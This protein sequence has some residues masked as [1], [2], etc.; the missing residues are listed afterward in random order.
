[1]S[2]SLESK[3]LAL[4]LET[5]RLGNEDW[6]S[7]I[8]SIV[9]EV[10]RNPQ[11][12]QREE[13]K[14]RLVEFLRA[15]CDPKTTRVFLKALSD[16]L[17]VDLSNLDQKIQ[18]RPTISVSKMLLTPRMLRILEKGIPE[19]VVS[20][21]VLQEITAFFNTGEV[22][23][24]DGNVLEIR[25][26]S[27]E[28][29]DEKLLGATLSRIL[30]LLPSYCENRLNN[31][32]EIWV[33][34]FRNRDDDL[35]RE[36]FFR[37]NHSGANQFKPSIK[38]LDAD[39]KQALEAMQKME[40]FDCATYTQAFHG[41]NHFKTGVPGVNRQFLDILERVFSQ[42]YRITSLDCEF[43]VEDRNL[44]HRLATLLSTWGPSS[45]LDRFILRTDHASIVQEL[46]PVI[47]NKT[48]IPF[49]CI[50][51]N[52]D[53]G[54]SLKTL[55]LLENNQK[56]TTLVILAGQPLNTE[57]MQALARALHRN[58]SLT[59]LKISGFR[60]DCEASRVLAQALHTHKL[61]DA[62]FTA[63]L[64]SRDIPIWADM[65]GLNTHLTC[66]DLDINLLTPRIEM[67][68]A[69]LARNRTIKKLKLSIRNPIEPLDIRPLAEM[70]RTQHSLRYF[71]FND[72][73]MG[74]AEGGIF[75]R[76]LRSNS[77]LQTLHL[78]NTGIG[79]QT[80]QALAEVLPGQSSLRELN[81]GSNALNDEHLK[82]LAKGLQ[83]N[84]SILKLALDKNQFTPQGIVD[85]LS[86]LQMN[87]ALMALNLSSSSNESD[88]DGLYR[89]LHRLGFYGEERLDLRRGVL[90][91]ETSSEESFD[92]F[93]GD[94]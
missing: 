22:C 2:L 74:D 1:M 25:R 19:E 29:Q 80:I 89:E 18:L 71:D 44:G 30:E 68:W 20:D 56:L 53:I 43:R 54:A 85:F 40:G 15:E 7:P 73:E 82:I 14:A 57:G 59:K 78:S 90:Q 31:L 5:Y 49:L 94:E 36:L 72:Y 50:V 93:S 62:E 79:T 66:L 24:S 42:G 65:I 77:T 39:Q 69:A 9:G 34:A 8:W 35:K 67:L 21:G 27:L 84:G 87:Q 76:A 10:L 70:L 32:F 55:R 38:E 46:L 51:T 47:L 37:C 86:D 11:S 52:Q 6:N 63:S 60:V 88:F 81:L 45:F 13:L 92:E 28:W 16:F 83:Q 3:T 91:E 33:F 61:E 12:I 64:E 58:N 26:L 75:V 48:K 41:Q 4:R 23:F 17:G